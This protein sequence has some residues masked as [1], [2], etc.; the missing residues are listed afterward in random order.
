MTKIKKII[1]KSAFLS[2]YQ[3]MWPFIRPYWFRA[4]LAML[5]TLPV[6]M[7]DA[8]IA[9]SL[10]PYM[11]VVLA[12]KPSNYSLV[13]PLFIVVFGLLQGIF[14]YASTYFNTW[15]GRKISN[16]VKLVLF[17]KLMQQ[18]ATFFDQETSGQI[19]LRF[20]QDADAAC[21]GL[22]NNVKVFVTRV[23]SSVSL[24][25]VLFFN[26]WQLAI[27]A[28]AMLLG[29]L[30]PLTTV[31]KRLTSLMD[32]SIFSGAQVATHYNETFN[33][34]RVIASYNL[35][36]YQGQRFAETL[37]GLFKIGMKMTQRTGMISPMMYFIA[38]LGVALVIWAGNHLIGTQQISPGNFVS[39][40][41]ALIML[42]TPIKAIGN[43]YTAVQGA[44]MAMERVWDILEYTPS[45][46]D[47]P[48][49]IELHAPIQSIEWQNVSFAYVAN[50]PVLKNIN[51]RVE[52]GQ[53]IALVGNSGGGK[54]TFANLLPRFYDVTQGSIA[55][56]GHDIRRYA[57]HSLRA[58]IAIVFQDNFLFAGTIRENIALGYPNVSD[59]MLWQVLRNACLEEFV[60]GLSHGL[61]TEI[62]ER[63][64]LLSGG[65]RQRVAIAR[66]F[67]KNAPIVILDEATSALDNKSESVVQQA[68]SN[69]MQDR[70]VFVIAHRLS[71][72][73]NADK[74]IVLDDGEI[75]EQGTHAMLLEHG[76][77]M[78]KSLYQL[79]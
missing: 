69:L 6:G 40:I 68:I 37:R 66:A 54:S 22:I 45:I 59:D 63:G 8:T 71:T 51:L 44:F 29:V 34:N 35:A 65:Q 3:K 12:G 62:G 50:K 19:Q 21:G 13:L 10:Q 16:D 53:T 33:G 20:N 2:N 43:N 64:V 26:S 46:T 61:D 24:I 70:T 38:S 73:K 9:W 30:Y 60:R 58:Q 1:T 48:D 25:S 57:L 72:I 52:A 27:I 4:L 67:L 32:R 77:G 41:A 11:D 39:F 15:V 76:T 75:V 74:I 36:A 78:Y 18:E 14:N 7:M 49:A 5:I 79:A 55:I 31:R 23:V 28:V 17:K 47:A 42:Y 56:N